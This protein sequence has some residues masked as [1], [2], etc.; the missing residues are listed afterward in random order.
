MKHAIN[1]MKLFLVSVIALPAIAFSAIT[2]YSTDFEDPMFVV[3]NSING[4]DGWTAEGAA[5]IRNAA[6]NTWGTHGK[7]LT[8]WGT[9]ALPYGPIL[10]TSAHAKVYIGLD[11]RPA[12]GTTGLAN[13]NGGGYIGLYGSGTDNG[14]TLIR[15]DSTGVNTGNI[16]ATNGGNE[17]YVTLGTWTFVDSNT[18]YHFDMVVDNI[19]KTTAVSIDGGS[20][21]TLAWGGSFGSYVSS[22]TFNQLWFR[23]GQNAGFAQT[24]VDNIAITV[25]EPATL[26]LLL[27]GT[28]IATLKRRKN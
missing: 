14:V 13:P 25:P 27:L 6:Y 9:G 26:S 16:V 21:V 19:N 12:D 2:T 17:N 22:G 15:L 11:F 28:V 7:Y 18:N 20:A 8:G 4:V 24:A 1:I 3:G 23:G 5:I 10:D